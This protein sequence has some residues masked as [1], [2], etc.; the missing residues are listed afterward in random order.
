MVSAT[1]GAV[2]RVVREVIAPELKD[3]GFRRSG[4]VWTHASDV[5]HR[6]LTVQRSRHNDSNGGGFTLNLRLAFPAAGDAPFVTPHTRASD[7]EAATAPGWHRIGELMSVGR[8]HWW[9]VA[10]P[11]R[12][13]VVDSFVQGFAR[14]WDDEIRP[15]VEAA[16]VPERFCS[17]LLDHSAASGVAAGFAC[18][19]RL[20]DAGL[21][22]ALYERALEL[23]RQV[24]PWPLSAD[25]EWA[26]TG[27]V[28]GGHVARLQ[29]EERMRPVHYA[30]AQVA[31]MG[32]RIGRRLE[33]TDHERA[34]DG[35]RWAVETVLPRPWAS[36][37]DHDE[38]RSFAAR[39]G[40][41]I[42]PTSPSP[43]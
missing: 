1:T 26:V 22:D 8:D 40:V 32:E 20:G 21:G 3:A 34:V 42:E 5:A 6:G 13:G 10:D 41:A 28:V 4:R 18:A 2:D 19:V 23:A 16:E 14:A 12:P 39:L 17:H 29:A 36:S 27:V 38:A 35:L 33:G 25:G 30:W 24:E 37:H 31:A 43:H 9:E 15:I 7:V 11:E